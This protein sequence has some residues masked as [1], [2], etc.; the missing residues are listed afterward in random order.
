MGGGGLVCER[1]S[2]K[3]AHVHAWIYL[4]VNTNSTKTTDPQDGRAHGGQ[5][6][7]LC[8]EKPRDGHGVLALAE[9]ASDTQAG[10]VGDSLFWDLLWLWLWLWL[11]VVEARAWPVVRVMYTD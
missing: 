7:D 3:H 5:H 2:H 6:A 4:N 11:V 9:H 10:D 8:D 1:G